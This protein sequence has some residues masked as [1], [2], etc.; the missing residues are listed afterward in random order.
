[1]KSIDVPTLKLFLK[2]HKLI[3]SAR[4]RKY[5]AT[6]IVKLIKAAEESLR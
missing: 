1:M 5:S 2:H 6:A 3:A 4:K